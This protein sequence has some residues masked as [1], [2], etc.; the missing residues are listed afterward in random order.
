VFTLVVAQS[1]HDDPPPSDDRA[2]LMREHIIFAVEQGEL[3]PIALRIYPATGYVNANFVDGPNYGN[4][5]VRTR[6]ERGP[7][8]AW[9]LD[10]DGRIEQSERTITERALYEASFRY[11]Y[12]YRC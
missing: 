6:G 7:K 1:L 11:R 8:L 9:D 3:P 4:D 2:Q 10:R 12:C 5:I